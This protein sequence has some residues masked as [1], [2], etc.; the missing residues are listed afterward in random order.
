MDSKLLSEFFSAKGYIF[1][2]NLNLTVLGNCE[3]FIEKFK[4]YLDYHLD[5]KCIV[6]V[7]SLSFGDEILNTIEMNVLFENDQLS[8]NVRVFNDCQYV[9]PSVSKNEDVIDFN[10][11]L[12][13]DML[14]LNRRDWS[15]ISELQTIF[16]LY[17]ENMFEK[18][19]KELNEEER[20]QFIG[21]F[22]V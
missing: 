5:L 14:Q 1:T 3:D 18:I 9:M 21:L 17:W 15:I 20:S 2:S 19:N 11:T 16:L 10:K 7:V 12:R 22:K 13:E 8:I 6:Y 4:Q